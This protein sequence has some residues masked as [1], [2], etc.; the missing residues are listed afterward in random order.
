MWSQVVVS[1]I[2]SCLRKIKRVLCLFKGL[3]IRLGWCLCIS[4]KLISKGIRCWGRHNL[5]RFRKWKRR[6]KGWLIWPSLLPRKE[7]PMGM[8]IHQ[9][10]KNSR[11]INK[12][13]CKSRIIINPMLLQLLSTSHKLQQ[14]INKQIQ[15]SIP[16]NNIFNN[17]N[18]K[19]TNPYK[20]WQRTPYQL[21]WTRKRL[22]ENYSN[23]TKRQYNLYYQNQ[24]KKINIRDSTIRERQRRFIKIGSSLER[25]IFSNFIT[26][27]KGIK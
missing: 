26:R 11:I 9:K 10:I 8:M 16:N 21:Y 27:S 6:K 1:G 17:N 24:N 23:N 15:K 12:K 4:K 22:N 20:T 13:Y 7:M 14:K 5:L 19:T 25:Q 2:K 18:N 3:I